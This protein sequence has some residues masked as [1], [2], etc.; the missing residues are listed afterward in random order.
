MTG[1][2][3]SAPR[4]LLEALVRQRRWS[5]QDLCDAYASAAVEIGLGLTVSPQH[6]GRWLGGK[7]KGL[8][9]PS[10]RR[11]LEHLFGID[12]VKLF[13]PAG[14]EPRQLGGAAGAPATVG[15]PPNP[16]EEISMAA[17][18]AARFAQFAEQ[19][20]VG[21][22]TLDQ[23]HA[24]IRRVVAQY[25][26]RPVYPLFMEL[27][28]L[29]GRAFEKI[30]GRQFPDQTRD[31]YLVTGLLCGLL[32]NA[33][34]DLGRLDAAETQARTAFLCAELSGS[35]WLRAWI[36]GT[37]ALVAYWDERPM[38]AI[39]LAEDGRR[40]P[41][42]R[43]TALVRL[44]AIEARAHG[45][46]RDARSVD[47]ALGVAGDARSTVVDVDDPGGMMIFPEAKQRFYSSTAHLWLGNAESVR[48]AGSDAEHAVRLYERDPPEHRRLG[49]LNLARLDLATSYLALDQVEGAAVELG[50]VI[51]VSRRRPTDSVMRRLDQ[52]A[53]VLGRPRFANSRV[54]SDLRDEI[55]NAIGRAA[56]PALPHGDTR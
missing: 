49:E 6:A 54:A 22:H 7:L 39:R 20:N 53:A 1:P 3:W 13:G 41:P 27:R 19:T 52:V 10:Q 45:R 14:T 34:F 5:H 25:P 40:Y 30:E 23:F 38:D 37:Q 42:E 50:N 56:V 46:M 29:R 2:Q 8:P 33:S 28:S 32:A 48:R 4:T 15:S 36:R 35:N 26:N 44:A 51:D 43:G 11:V 24:D 55:V 18:E 31:L 17:D 9:Y 47:A 12:V 21:P 16:D